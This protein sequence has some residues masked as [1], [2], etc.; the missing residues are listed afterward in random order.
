MK[1]AGTTIRTVATDRRHGLNDKKVRILMEAASILGNLG[2]AK[3]HEAKKVIREEKERERFLE[4]AEWEAGKLI[5]QWPAETVAERIALVEN[6][7]YRRISEHAMD[8]GGLE[9]VEDL[10]VDD[11][12]REIARTAAWAAW[13]RKIPVQE[14]VVEQREKFNARLASP[15]PAARRLIKVVE[16]MWRPT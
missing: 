8:R 1:A 12:R 14:A 4:R 6:E 11:A 10:R 16:A 13:E 3:G 15:S 5:E 2:A 9:H 7:P